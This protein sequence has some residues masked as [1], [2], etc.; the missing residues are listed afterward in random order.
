[1]R[2]IFNKNGQQES[3]LHRLDPRSKLIAVVILGGF[4]LLNSIRTEPVL[5]VLLS[6]L[7][8]P[9]ICYRFALS[10]IIH[11]LVKIYP[12]ILLFTFMLPFRTDYEG[13]VHEFAGIII[14]AAGMTEFVR[15]N[16]VFVSLFILLT[17]F[18]STTSTAQMLKS[19]EAS[20]LPGWIISVFA[21][22]IKFLYLSSLELERVHLAWSSRQIRLPWLMKIK[23][24]AKMS[25][26]VLAR[27][28]GRNEKVFNA[29][30][31]RGFDGTTRSSAQL[32]WHRR[33]SFLVLFSAGY[34]AFWQLLIKL[35][36]V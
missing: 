5:P 32:S 9:L 29:M 14:S 31:S 6:V 2:F 7:A 28:V 8:L 35:F 23:S 4:V 27:S 30:I 10:G 18:I 1:M 15:I 13:T 19:L 24:I 22:L 3:I 21:I 36:G 33:D 11:R 17:L 12:M 25:A 34:I 16:L 26:V 20:R